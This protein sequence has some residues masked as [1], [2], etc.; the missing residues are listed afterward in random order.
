MRLDG[1]NRRAG[2]GRQRKGRDIPDNDLYR[3][4]D[5]NAARFDA[6]REDCARVLNPD[7]PSEYRDADEAVAIER[8]ILARPPLACEL[9]IPNEGSSPEL[10]VSEIVREVGRR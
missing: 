5:A 3:V 1:V 9:R 4:A 6:P 10:V 2:L 8:Q 7:R